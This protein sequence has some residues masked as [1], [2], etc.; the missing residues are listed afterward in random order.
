MNTLSL[1]LM[2]PSEHPQN[3]L[4][5]VD[6][7][8]GKSAGP[9]LTDIHSKCIYRWIWL[10]IYPHEVAMASFQEPMNAHSWAI[11]EDWK[12]EPS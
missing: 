12:W 5:I 7:H 8:E 2:T 10:D 3:A 4:D 1:V 6:V 9:C 11:V